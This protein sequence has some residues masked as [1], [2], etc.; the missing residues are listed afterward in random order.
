MR[1][2]KSE[3]IYLS[4]NEA[5]IWVDFVRI[6]DSLERQSENPQI[7]NLTNN[8]KACLNNLFKKIEGIEE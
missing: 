1:I 7:L 6:L 4:Q 2:V 5:D 3:K 8:I